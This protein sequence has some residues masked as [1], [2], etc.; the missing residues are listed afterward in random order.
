VAEA[1]STSLGN[2]VM[3]NNLFAF[4]SFQSGNHS[5]LQGVIVQDYNLSM[6]NNSMFYSGNEQVVSNVTIDNTTTHPQ[7]TL[8]NNI[9]SNPYLNY[10]SYNIV[11]VK[12]PQTL[13][14]IKNNVFFNVKTNSGNMYKERLR[15]QETGEI[16]EGFDTLTGDLANA[17]ITDNVNLAAPYFEGFDHADDSL[18][19]TIDYFAPKTTSSSIDIGLNAGIAGITIDNDLKGN[20]RIYNNETIDAG[21]YECECAPLPPPPP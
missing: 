3:I 7:I 2:L 20:T 6:V 5:N 14:V 12:T 16:F 9:F 15:I 10:D 1:G 17:D 13:P 11:Y 19:T 8:I 18:F 21:A 4:N